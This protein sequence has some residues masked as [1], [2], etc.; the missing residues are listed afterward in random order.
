MQRRTFLVAGCALAL[1][2]AAEPLHANVAQRRLVLRYRGGQI[3]EQSIAVSR[4][5]DRVD[6]ALDLSVAVQ[7]FGITMYR[8]RLQAAETWAGGQLVSLQSSANNNGTSH[9]VGATRQGADLLI[10]GSGFSGRV[11]GN[12]G[13]TSYWNAD[14]L[15]RGTWINLEDGRPMQITAQE[16]GAERFPT[17][18]GE[19][20]A[21][22]WR[23]GG[24]S[25]PIDLFY[26]ERGEWAGSEFRAQGATARF[27]LEDGTADLRP[28]WTRS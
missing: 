20:T 7:V 1:S 26:D 6:V 13:T 24:D 17:R 19:V 25:D 15:R 9:S 5:G 16:V 28:M 10:E 3:G 23:I 14:L 4:T 2:A 21:V 27:V 12:P 11:T 8:Y 22:R 18:S